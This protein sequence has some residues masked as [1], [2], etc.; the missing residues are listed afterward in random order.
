L[1]EDLGAEP[2]YC[3]NVGM[4]HKETIPLDQMGQWI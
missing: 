4:S 2:L 3:I 1:A